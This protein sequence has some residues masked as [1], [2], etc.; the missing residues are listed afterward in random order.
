MSK[1]DEMRKLHEKRMKQI[2]NDDRSTP[3][4]AAAEQ[5]EKA[6]A[7]PVTVEEKK[8]EKKEDKA[9]T[10]QPVTT[11]KPKTG[12]LDFNYRI[13]VA[14]CGITH[15]SVL[16]TSECIN[17]LK[18]RSAQMG[19]SQQ[20]YFNMLIEEDKQNNDTSTDK[21]LMKQINLHGKKSKSITLTKDNSM[22]LK[23][24]SAERGLNQTNYANY[25]ILKEHKR[26]KT[27]G[28]RPGKYDL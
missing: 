9:S 7:V 21:E 13:A 15:A 3:A 1:I 20:D 24:A 27:E 25:L 16:L 2:E 28:R 23:R 11:Q 8:P 19:M 18:T 17:L 10:I 6:V 5:A 4:E 26:E 14:A 22:Y 12:L